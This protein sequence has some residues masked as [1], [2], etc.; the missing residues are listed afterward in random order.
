MKK[1]YV[2]WVGCLIGAL[3]L[4]PYVLAMDLI[5]PDIA[6]TQLVGLIFVQAAVFCGFVI[7]LSSKILPKT[8]LQPFQ[9]P[10]I[11]LGIV[12][13]VLIGSVLYALDNTFFSQ[14]ALSGAK[15]P[16]W[17]ALLAS[18]Y[19]GINEEVILRLFLFSTLYYFLG[20]IGRKTEENRLVYL[21]ITN[22]IVAILF[23]VG[24]LPAAFQ[25]VEPSMIETSRVLFLNGIPGL[26]FG[27][28]YWSRGLG[29]AMIAHLTTDVMIH[30]LL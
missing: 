9:R 11:L 10:R 28:L 14:S 13:G 8:D 17:V 19:G 27:R 24:H 16:F 29:T 23:G 5:P 4:V 18:L 12:T 1:Y 15:P 7:Y 20:R 2:L 26:V 6:T 21:W 25:L 22:V 30:G 3:S